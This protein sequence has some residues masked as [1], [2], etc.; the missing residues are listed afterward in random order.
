MQDNITVEV[1]VFHDTS[2][3]LSH[4][5]ASSPYREVG[6]V[7]QLFECLSSQLFTSFVGIDIICRPQIHLASNGEIGL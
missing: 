4:K 1:T 5:A 6:G 7:T 3:T 2:L